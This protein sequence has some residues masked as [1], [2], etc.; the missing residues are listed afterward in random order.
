MVAGLDVY[1]NPSAEH[2][3]GGIGG[4]VDVRTRRPLDLKGFTATAAISG[5]Y[6]DMVKS[7][8]PEYFGLIAD[9]WNVGEGEMGLLLAA[10]FQKSWNRSDN[11]PGP[12]GANLRQN[13]RSR[14]QPT[15]AAAK[16]G[17][18]LQCRPSAGRA[19]LSVPD[20]R[21]Q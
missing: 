20:I 11:A 9:R 15:A 13:R 1:K 4:L 14:Q 12:G 10:N 18:G 16:L 2:I 8:Q 7:L 3:E 5:K 19:D 17:R 6:N 21:H